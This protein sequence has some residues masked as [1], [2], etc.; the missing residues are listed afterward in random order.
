M[1][2]LRRVNQLQITCP[3]QVAADF[4]ITA[5][6]DYAQGRLILPVVP[7]DY[8]RVQVNETSRYGLNTL[9]IKRSRLGFEAIIR[10]GG[11][12]LRAC[13]E[14]LA[15][16]SEYNDSGDHSLI[17]IRDYV[18]PESLDVRAAMASIQENQPIAPYTTRQ[19]MILR[20]SIQAEGGGYYIGRPGQSPQ[21][22]D[23]FKFAFHEWGMR[24]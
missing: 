21:S 4:G 13:I 19:G 3:S 16:L 18:Y 23:G 7:G 10:R 24:Y 17:E 15:I 1:T 14:Y 8:T 22:K 2:C 5:I 9:Q 12:N 11:A 6:E 20:D